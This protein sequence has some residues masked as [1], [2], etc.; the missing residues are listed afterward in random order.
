MMDSSSRVALFASLKMYFGHR[1][2][3]EWAQAIA[4]IVYEWSER[5]A[6]SAEVVVFPDFT[7]LHSVAPILRAAGIAVG[8]QDVAPDPAG[9]QTGEV[10]ARVLVELGCT[11]VEVGHAER[12]HL[13]G[14]TDEMVARKVANSIAHG[15]VPLVCVGEPEPDDSA[16]EF[17]SHQLT[18]S[19]A[20]VV[21]ADKRVRVVVAYEP[22]WAI[23][24]SSSA[25]VA[26]ISHVVD[27]LRRTLAAHPAIEGSQVIYGGGAG[28]ETARLLHSTTDGLFLGRFLHDPAEFERLLEANAEAIE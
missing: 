12:R 13:F 7:S 17:C 18:A 5:R 11:F 27:A 16:A 24:A 1:Q 25:A 20:Q 14:E 23:G 10:S 28:P 22:V 21:E 15:L 2:T 8:A 6:F 4:D 26:H 9:A 19:L 3:L